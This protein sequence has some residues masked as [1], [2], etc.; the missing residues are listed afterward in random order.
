WPWGSGTITRP[1]GSSILYVPRTPY[2]PPG[3]LREA[4]SYPQEASRFEQADFEK[5]LTRLNLQRLLPMLDESGHWEQTLSEDEAT[6]LVVARVVLHNC[7]WV[8]VDEVL[9]TADANT[10]SLVEDILAKD[11]KHS[12]VIHIGRPLVDDR[13]FERVVHLI[14]DPTVRT[15]ARKSESQ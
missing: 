14:K 11:L 3:T 7:A 9:D 13:T 12:G 8:I 2:W 10:R 1:K 6:S 5:A 4:L 15:L